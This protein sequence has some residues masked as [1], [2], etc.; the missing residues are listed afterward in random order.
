MGKYHKSGGQFP[1]GHSCHARISTLSE[2]YQVLTLCQD[3]TVCAGD[4]RKNYTLSLPENSLQSSGCEEEGG[5]KWV[6]KTQ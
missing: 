4:A 6:T 5:G 3:H 2:Y 1:T